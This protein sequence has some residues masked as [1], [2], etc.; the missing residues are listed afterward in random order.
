MTRL[1]RAALIADLVHRLRSAG[2]WAG[3]THIQKAAYVLQELLGT[4]LGVEFVLYKHG[5]FSFELRDE[6]TRMRADGLLDQELVPPYGPRLVPTDSS[7]DLR[8]RLKSV[9]ASKEAAVSFVAQKLANRDIFDLEQLSTALYVRN[10]DSSA[11]RPIIGERI[12]QLKPHISAE[13]A[14]AAV[15]Q[16]S[17]LDAEAHTARL[18]A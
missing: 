11:G 5:P 3:E 1:E 8:R 7:Q 16:L 14:L 10:A 15:D 17:Q 9:L 12:R 13:A 4:E 18:I 6:L 2:G